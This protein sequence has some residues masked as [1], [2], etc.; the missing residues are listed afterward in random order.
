MYSDTLQPSI[1]SVAVDDALMFADVSWDAP[2][3]VNLVTGYDVQ[4]A[5]VPRVGGIPQSASLHLMASSSRY[6]RSYRATQSLT[7]ETVYTFQVRA[8]TSVGTSLWSIPV[9]VTTL[10]AG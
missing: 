2:S 9:A 10:P 3:E 1:S 8:R 5:M 4:V 7:P 6:S